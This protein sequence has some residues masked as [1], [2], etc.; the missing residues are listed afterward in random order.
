MLSSFE[1]MIMQPTQSSDVSAAAAPTN[2]KER[3]NATLQH[4][5]N[6]VREHFEKRTSGKQL[7]S[8][9][10]RQAQEMAFMNKKRKFDSSYQYDSEQETK[11]SSSLDQYRF[12][13]SRIATH[14]AQ[15][16]RTERQG[17]NAQVPVQK[18]PPRITDGIVLNSPPNQIQITYNDV[19][20]GRGEVSVSYPNST[21]II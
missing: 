13:H 2:K 16:V 20:C 15:M 6:G 10:A 3:A 17:K 8:A 7:C 4:I 12:F 5:A 21:L 19:V 1:E 9:T 11:R 18:T 14:M